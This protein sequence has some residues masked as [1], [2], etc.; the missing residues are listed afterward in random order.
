MLGQE[1]NSTQ[2]RGFASTNYGWLP[3]R[4]NAFV[5]LPLTYTSNNTPNPLLNT[6][7]TIT[8]R[9]TNNMGLYSTLSYSYDNRYVFNFSVRS[10]ASNRFGQFTGEKFNPVYAGG[11]RW[12][13][14]YEKWAEKMPW[15]SA[16]SLRTSFGFQRN[17]VANVS[18]DLIARMP[19][20]PPALVVDQFTGEARLVISSLPYG[21]LRWEK[22]A[23]FNAGVDVGFF[24]NR[25]TG[26]VDYYVKKGK[27]IITTMPVP[28]EYGVLSMPI[29]G[30]DLTNSGLEI[31]LNVIPVQTKDYTLSIGLNTS[32]NFNKLEN[33][34]VQNYHWKVAT[35]G[36]LYVKGYPVSGFWAF[37]FTG[38]DPANGLP[39]FDLTTSGDKDVTKDPTAYMKYMGKL[40][41][42]FTGGFNISFRYKMFSIF[43]NWYLQLGGKR[44]LTPA[45]AGITSSSVGLPTEYE[46]LSTELLQRWTP[47]HTTTDFPGLPSSGLPNFLLPDGKTY[48]NLYDLYNYSSARVVN[49]ST[50]RVNAVNLSYTLPRRISDWVH[51]K[52]ISASLGVSNAFDWVSKDY[53][54]RDAEVA[55][56]AQPRTRSYSLR[57]NVSF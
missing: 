26:S 30:G 51:A 33:V 25:I 53:K 7:K 47:G 42:D 21:D 13:M 3:E 23:S 50:L 1:A 19:T 20:T 55:T 28:V 27:D 16:F 37:D 57:C 11:V 46:N 15:L 9:T 43:S 49:A 10:D 5:A 48:S 45:Y 40:N 12:N 31:N 38:I 24:K 34:G 56:G 8:D 52:M 39:T 29:N 35:S 14:M 32:K 2:Y 17:I 18:P 41:P 4:G 54:G 44:F 22:T 6:P 36:A